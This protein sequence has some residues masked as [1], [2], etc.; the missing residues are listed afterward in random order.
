MYTHVALY[1]REDTESGQLPGLVTALVACVI[2]V[3]T[4]SLLSGLRK[5]SVLIKTLIHI[6]R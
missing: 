2:L 5:T 3:N 4:L 1:M 6:Q